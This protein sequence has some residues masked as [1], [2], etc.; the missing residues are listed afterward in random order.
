MTIRRSS[1]SGEGVKQESATKPALRV[2]VQKACRG[3]GIPV[4]AQI[5]E[6]VAFALSGVLTGEVTV[7]VVDEA[8]SAALNGDYRGR[9]GPTN[10]LSFPA[11]T[12]WPE[13]SDQPAGD[14]A[15]C[16]PVLAREAAEQ[17]KTLAEHWAHIMIHGALHLAGYDHE[18]AAEAT[19]MEARER[20]L[21]AALGV[22]DPYRERAAPDG[23]TMACKPS[24][25]TAR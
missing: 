13:L 11:D 18:T 17:G 3:A 15:V 20:E 6:W 8:E 21:L 23:G 7:R 19:V 9:Q 24:P 16:A 12:S 22:A 10:V 1:L 5:R 4:A 2:V 14:I 25:R